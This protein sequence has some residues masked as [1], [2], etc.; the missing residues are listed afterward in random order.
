MFFHDLYLIILLKK[1]REI[2]KGKKKLFKKKWHGGWG[3]S[4]GA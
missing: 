1:Y 4:I 3:G 2:I